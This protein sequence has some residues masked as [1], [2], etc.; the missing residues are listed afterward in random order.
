MFTALFFIALTALGLFTA[1][2]YGQPWDEPWEQDILRMNGNQYRTA[3]GIAGNTALTST[4]E[5]PAS[6]LIADS[7]EKDHGECAY[8]PLLWLVDNANIPEATRMVIWHAYTW[9][10][11]MAGAAALWLVCRRLGLSRIYSGAAV[12]FLVLS[13]R[14]FAEGHY[15]N[16]DI[17][18]FSLTLLTLWLSLRLMEKP[19]FLR[20]A[21]FSLSGAA[22]ANMKIVGLLIWGL[23]ALFVLVRQ[24]AGRRMTGRVWGVAAFALLSFAAFYALLTP[25]L[26]PDPYAYLRYVLG[27]ALHFSRWQNDVL[28]RGTVFHLKTAS[29]PWYYLPY[30]ILVTTPLWLIALIGVGQFFTLGL[31]LR[32]RSR[33]FKDDTATGLLLCT[34]LWTLPLLYTL[35]AQPV[36]YNGW[37]HNYF[38]YGPM[39]ALA[40][41][42][43]HT[44]SEKLRSRGTRH[45]LRLR[46]AGAGLLA[47]MMAFTGAQAGLSHPNEYVYYN[48]LLLN[49]NVPEYLEL[50]YWNVSVLQTLRSLL[51]KLPA[52]GSVTISGGELWSQTGLESAWKLL[53]ETEQARLTVVGYQGGTAD[54]VLENTT[55]AVLGDWQAAEYMP[56]IAETESFGLPMCTV[57]ARNAAEGGET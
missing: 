50:D 30:M 7:Q 39:L 22:A 19:G 21:L 9:L 51:A 37:R 24:L 13:P 29:L 43:L 17:V 28:F 48:A 45:A 33:T 31:V 35:L 54:Y 27:N 42:G 14:F 23:C 8:Y 56:V 12:L 25:A 10:L 18:L 41:Y 20:A 6:G 15:N 1:G 46:Y 26:W 5:A 3:L 34:L 16:K 49:R 52:Q 38:L 2:D 47:L 40:A 53:D 11:F 44:L 36:L 32:L 55:Y 57:Y 4:M